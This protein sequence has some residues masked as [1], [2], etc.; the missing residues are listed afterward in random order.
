MNKRMNNS[1]LIIDSPLY[2]AD[3]HPLSGRSSQPG[4]VPQPRRGLPLIQNSDRVPKVSA[5]ICQV[6]TAYQSNGLK[7]CHFQ[8]GLLDFGFQSNTFYSSLYPSPFPEIEK[9]LFSVKT[10]DLQND[11]LRKW[12]LKTHHLLSSS[13]CT[14]IGVKPLGNVLFQQV[15]LRWCNC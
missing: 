15:S 12:H 11:T 7:S 14:T 1:Y 2:L 13:T 8:V 6:T 5:N 3:I 10:W 4:G 9:F